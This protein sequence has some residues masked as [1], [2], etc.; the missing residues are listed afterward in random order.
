ME[1]QQALYSRKKLLHY[2]AGVERG[3]D[4]KKERDVNTISGNWTTSRLMISN[5]TIQE[6]RALYKIA[7]SCAEFLEL[8]G[9]SGIF[10]P[11]FFEHTIEHGDLPPDGSKDLYSI[12]TMRLKDSDGIIGYAEYYHG[13]PEKGILWIN[14][15][16]VHRDF[17][18]RGF[19]REF[20]A[21][22]ME[23][24]RRLMNIEEIQVGVSLKNWP[25]VKFWVRCDFREIVR[26]WGDDR[27]G[28][29]TNA[30][31]VLS[32]KL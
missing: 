14:S 8:E 28:P 3:N 15:L 12:Q 20:V 21:G 1:L 10:D 18:C 29:R 30:G 25:A 5:S 9:I 23:K 22:L 19:G 32:L 31:L 2:I 6:S 11:S 7:Q 17:Q 4:M 26:Y 13:Y 16:A 27:H 24:A